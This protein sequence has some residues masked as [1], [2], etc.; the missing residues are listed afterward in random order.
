MD[1]VMLILRL[2]HIFAGVFWVGATLAMNFYVG[3]AAGTTAEAGGQ[4]LH[5]LVTRARFS[6]RMT[7]AGI[8]TVLA[9]YSMYWLDSD[10]FRSAWTHSGPGIGFGIG[11]AA[12]LLSLIFRI[13]ANRNMT[14][15]S[16][17]AAEINGQPAH[18]KTQKLVSLQRNQARLNMLNIWALIIAVLFMAT[19]RYLVF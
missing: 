12:G 8:L 15:L 18:E 7:V 16:R 2:T 1:F 10:G 5:H 17:L 14:A 6:T 4:V 9:G 3:P 13:L 11:G 19:A